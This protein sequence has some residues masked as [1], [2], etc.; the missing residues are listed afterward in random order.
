[1]KKGMLVMTMFV[2]LSFLVSVIAVSPSFAKQ[3]TQNTST[4]KQ[5]PQQGPAQAPQ[6]QKPRFPKN[7]EKLHTVFWELEPLR[8][9]I[10]G[11]SKP[12]NCQGTTAA[13]NV[14]V[15]PGQPL[16]ITCYYKVKT[17]PINDITEADVKAW[18]WGRSYTLC[19]DFP[20][21]DRIEEIRTLP[22]F[23][24]AD[25]KL[26]KKGGQGN[27]PK[28]RTEPMVLKLTMP[29]KLIGVFV[30]DFKDVIKE[31]H[32]GLSNWCCIS[33]NQ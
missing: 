29:E 21:F 19:Y 17:P 12:C 1:M 2:A 16:T 23:T 27:A 7:M 32:E 31:L 26:W 18:G 6:T 10:N 9:V 3:A 8:C 22:K 4:P 14:I 25:V 24:W 11:V 28:I 20:G 5:Q 30:V 13:I 33:I 15:T